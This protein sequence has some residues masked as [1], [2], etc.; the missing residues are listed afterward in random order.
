MGNGQHLVRSQLD[1]QPFHFENLIELL[2]QLHRKAFLAKVIATLNHHMDQFVAR[3]V[4]VGR[5]LTHS[6]ELLLGRLSEQLFNVAFLGT[7]SNQI[8]ADLLRLILGLFLGPLVCLL[9]FLPVLLVLLVL[10]LVFLVHDLFLYFCE[11]EEAVPAP[12]VGGGLG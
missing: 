8:I 9:L 7:A 3:E 6:L 10:F 1:G 2:Q 11:V 5:Y 12:P 4:T